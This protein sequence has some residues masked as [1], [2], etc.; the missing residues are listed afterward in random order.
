[1]LSQLLTRPSALGCRLRSVLS[2]ESRQAPF[3]NSLL[4]PSAADGW[5]RSILTWEKTNRSHSCPQNHLGPY[6][7]TRPAP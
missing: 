7:T 1:M 5:K 3:R 6:C 2:A 4:D